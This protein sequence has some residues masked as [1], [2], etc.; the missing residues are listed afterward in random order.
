MDAELGIKVSREQRRSNWWP[1]L[2]VALVAMNAVSLAN[3]ALLWAEVQQVSRAPCPCACAQ[4]VGAQPRAESR[5][6]QPSPASPGT[7]TPTPPEWVR[8]SLTEIEAQTNGRRLKRSADGDRDAEVSF[9]RSFKGKA[10]DST[11]LQVLMAA[12][13]ATKV[14]A[15]T[16]ARAELWSLGCREMIALLFCL[17]ATWFG[18]CLFL[19]FV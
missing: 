17:S 7:P 12:H 14:L 15:A 6:A 18:R 9:L 4:E 2:V 5:G 13:D 10:A 3:Q 1:L 19:R 8:E 16:T 11:R